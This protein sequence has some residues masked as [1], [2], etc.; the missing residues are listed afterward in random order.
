MR[1]LLVIGEYVEYVTGSTKAF[2]AGSISLFNIVVSLPST[3]SYNMG[4]EKAFVKKR[5]LKQGS[6]RFF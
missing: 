5:V 2:L 3:V 4:A 1:Q 6:E